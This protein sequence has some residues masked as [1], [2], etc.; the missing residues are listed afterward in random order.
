MRNENELSTEENFSKVK[1][2]MEVGLS[3]L[4]G[5]QA[6][7]VYCEYGDVYARQSLIVDGEKVFEA[8][9]GDPEDAC[10][11]RDLYDAHKAFK[12]LLKGQ[13]Y[14][15]KITLVQEFE[16]DNYDDYAAKIKELTT[17]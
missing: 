10:F 5:V 7:V 12:L 9:Q 14:N 16:F 1:K 4:P 8:R 13:E 17:K 2:Q 3:S 11:G 6:Y 15:R